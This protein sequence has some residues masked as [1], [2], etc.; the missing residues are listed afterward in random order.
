MRELSNIERARKAAADE[1]WCSLMDGDLAD[2][3]ENGEAD[4]CE[5]VQRHLAVI[6]GDGPERA[7]AGLMLFAALLGLLAVVG[8][9]STMNWVGGMLL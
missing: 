5:P 1:I 7:S 3:I 6:E 9:V 2:R 8:L 4:A